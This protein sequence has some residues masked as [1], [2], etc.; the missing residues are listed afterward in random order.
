ME[1]YKRSI[2]VYIYS[3]LR[4]F[5]FLFVRVSLEMV[6]YLFSEVLVMK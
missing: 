2:M 1:E 3:V 4:K 6:F 5:F